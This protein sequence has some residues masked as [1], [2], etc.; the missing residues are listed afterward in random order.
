MATKG[1]INDI[2]KVGSQ[3]YRDLQKANAAAYEKAVANSPLAG[4]KPMYTPPSSPFDYVTEGKEYSSLASTGTPWGESVYDNGYTNEEDWE[5]LGD[6]RANNQ[7][8]YAQIGAGLA[9][10]A[11]LAGTTFLDGTLGLIAGIGTAANEGRWSGI[12]DNDFTR[13][14]KEVTDWSEKALPNYYTQAEMDD[15]WYEHIN[16]N[17]IGDKFLKNV[18][19]SVGALASGGIWTKGLTLGGKLLKSIGL[20]SQA[21]KAPAAVKTLVGAGI[22]AVN[23][24]SIEALNNSTEWY[25]GHKADLDNRYRAMYENATTRDEVMAINQAYEEDLSKLEEDKAKMGN[26]DLLMNLPIL[27]ASNIVQFAKF[28]ANGYKTARKAANI[29]NRNGEYAA[30]KTTLGGVFHTTKDALTEGIEEISQKAAQNIAG[31]YYT[32]D[33]KNYYKAKMDP[34]AEQDTLSWM[35]SFAHGINETLNDSGSWEEFFIGSLTGAMGIPVIKTKANGKLGLGMAGGS[36]NTYM[37]YRDQMNRDQEIADRMNQRMKDPNFLNYYRGLIR[38]NKYQTA[39][40]A[41]VDRGDEFDYKNAEHA[42]MVSD[43]AMF[44]NAGKIG[45]LKTLISQAFDTSDENLDAIIRNTTSIQGDK[46]VGPYAQYA[47]I[48]NGQIVSNFGTEQD[49]KDMIEKLTKSKDEMLGAIDGYVKTKNDIDERVGGIITDEQLE[50]LTWMSSQLDNWAERAESIAGDVRGAIEPVVNSLMERKKFHERRKEALRVDGVEEDK[51]SKEYKE[52]AKAVKDYETAIDNLNLVKDSSN[53]GAV[54]AL[55]TSPK[56]TKTLRAMID[57]FGEDVMPKDTKNDILHKIDDII[58]LGNASKTYEEKLQ[59]YLTNPEKQVED[60]IAAEEEVAGEIQQ[61]AKSALAKRFDFTKSLDEI[62]DVYDNNKDEIDANGGLS[63]F[64]KSLSPED[65]K[66]LKKAIALRKGINALKD[67]VESDEDL[68]KSKIQQRILSALIDDAVDGADSFQ[69]FADKL[70]DAVLNGEVES[71][72]TEALEG[73]EDPSMV[74]K[75]VQEA[76]EKINEFLKKK[77]QETARG[78]DDIESILSA[79]EKTD[80]HLDENLANNLNDNEDKITEKDRERAQKLEQAEQEEPDLS[81]QAQETDDKID[82]A[83]STTEKEATDANKKQSKRVTRH[84]EK[85]P[86]HRE[87]QSRPQI[88]EFLLEGDYGQLYT[89]YLKSTP[90]AMPKGLGGKFSK[91]KY[92]TYLRIVNEYLKNKGAYHY[93]SHFLKAG[94]NGHIIEFTVDEELNKELADNGINTTVVLIQAV[95]AEG[96]KQI[97]GSLPIKEEFKL[98]TRSYKTIESKVVDGKLVE[99]KEWVTDDKTLAENRA[100]T[101]ALVNKITEEY[102]AWKKSKG[103]KSEFVG[104]VKSKVNSLRGG[105]LPL[106][107]DNRTVTEVFEGTDETPVI[108]VVDS[109]TNL[110]RYDNDPLEDRFIIPNTRVP[111]QVYIM[112]PNNRGGY[113]PAL[114]YSTPLTTLLESSPKDDWY[115]QQ[116]I[117]AIKD[118]PKETLDFKTKT[119]NLNKLFRIPGLNVQL[120]AGNEKTNDVTAATQLKFTFTKPDGSAGVTLLSSKNFD[121]DDVI[122]GVIKNIVSDANSDETPITTSVDITKLGDSESEQ[123]YRKNISKYLNVNLAGGHP[124]TINDWFTWTPTSVENNAAANE[125]VNPAPAQ[126]SKGGARKSGAQVTLEGKEYTIENGKVF[127]NDGTPVGQEEEKKV[128]KKDKENNNIK[129]D[130]AITIELGTDTTPKPKTINIYAG[131]NENAD[132]SNLAERLVAVNDIVPQNTPW[133]ANLGQFR[134]VEGAF[135]AQKLYFS[136]ISNKEK[137]SIGNKLREASGIEARKIGKTIFGLDVAKWDANSSKIMKAIIKA[138][139]E[140]NPQALQRLLDTGNATLTH[141]QAEIKVNQTGSMKYSYNKGIGSKRTDV[142]SNTTLEAIQNGER[143]ATTRFTKDGNIPYWSKLRVGDIVEWHDQVGNKVKVRITKPLTKLPKDTNAEEWSKK[144]GWSVE[145]FNKQ[146][147]PEI[148]KG[149]A[150]Q[151]EFEKVIDWGT[152]FPK[153]LMEVR[154]ELRATEKK[155]ENNTEFAVAAPAIGEET[156]VSAET[157][158]SNAKKVADIAAVLGS[159]DAANTTD[160]NTDTGTPNKGRSLKALRKAAAK[161][162]ALASIKPEENKDNGKNLLVSDTNDKEGT[163]EIAKKDIAVIK[164]MFPGLTDVNAVVLHKG[165]IKTVDEKGNPIDAYGQFKDGVLYI[166]DRSPKGTAYHEAFHYITDVLLTSEEKEDMFRAARD[167]FGNLSE[168]ELEE[169]TAEEFRDYMN[170]FDGITGPIVKIYRKLKNIVKS[171]MD[172]QNDLDSLFYSIYNGRYS[173]RSGNNVQEDTFKRDLLKY[174]SEKLSYDNLD[175]ETKE[176]LSMR[177]VSKEDY[178]ALDIEGKENILKCML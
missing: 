154:D 23:E 1:K 119:G 80:E 24:G 93:V 132:L 111:G 150:Y 72:V 141:K 16:A 136:T 14:M 5:Q 129:V 36:Y 143:T 81:I 27:M 83:A 174:K 175:A 101:V 39:M 144:E 2:R 79:G 4:V 51:Q 130:R 126:R 117:S 106:S 125:V 127:S 82:K 62:A 177:K 43:I 66:K 152:E 178:E 9:K 56:F 116:I 21:T 30:E 84:Q 38:H 55:A 77:L 11:I 15:P 45:D 166:S 159:T 49:K 64:L 19:F 122:L 138:S 176:L 87:D 44:D 114:A 134:T 13:A 139:F 57:G 169:K 32:N 65:G 85:G 17:W 78:I 103:E 168:M 148:E 115:I 123:E 53:K 149:E 34:Q 165:L 171:L 12:W 133:D 164:K 41:A 29:V 52:E 88:S 157:K 40:D 151:M 170:G 108:A 95:D 71:K 104:S 163:K 153:L 120:L 162:G 37:E 99:K 167:E 47:T 48:E 105:T 60:E 107:A 160:T 98:Q 140:Q 146:V 94:N 59:E 89:D 118:L 173:N 142:K 137:E 18:G 69:E 161:K 74:A 42:Q 172:K 73:Y 54:R 109:E 7:P 147:R 113:M 135:Q 6:I 86:S 155:K 121:N 145:F 35:K 76:E 58:K 102:K 3:T 61:N 128:L 70:K 26:A 96:N 50:E 63:E 20:V 90:Q 156:K 31:D 46:A 28:Y 124:Y 68:Q 131:T 100:G 91:E 25:E 92:L 10:G 112:I 97:V 158:A 33:V 110:K 8:W 75:V 67:D 22:S